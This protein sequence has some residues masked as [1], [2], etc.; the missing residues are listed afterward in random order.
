MHFPLKKELIN[1]FITLEFIEK[2]TCY[3]IIPAHKKPSFF[4]HPQ[5]K[6]P[7]HCHRHSKA[8][9]THNNNINSMI[10]FVSTPILLKKFSL[11][12]Y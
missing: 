11:Q 7:I 6:I 4:L 9:Y 12:N 8:K 5:G 10:N 3:T 2:K 1:I